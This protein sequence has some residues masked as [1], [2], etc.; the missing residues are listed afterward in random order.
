MVK[1]YSWILTD[2]ADGTIPDQSN[3]KV[4]IVDELQEDDKVS[5]LDSV[6]GNSFTGPGDVVAGRH[7]HS[8]TPSPSQPGDGN[9]GNGRDGGFCDLVQSLEVMIPI[10]EITEDNDPHLE[11]L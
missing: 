2:A 5:Q 8:N 4:I 1:D 11:I 3:P 7:G 9:D 10:S 6:L